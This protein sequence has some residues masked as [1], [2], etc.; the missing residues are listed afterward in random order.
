MQI[1]CQQAWLQWHVCSYWVLIRFQSKFISIFTK[2]ILKRELVKPVC[3]VYENKICCCC[4]KFTWL[5]VICFP[6]GGQQTSLNLIEIHI[7]YLIITD[8][9]VGT[10]SVSFLNTNSLVFKL[11]IL[12]FLRIEEKPEEDKKPMV[13]TPV[14]VDT[15]PVDLFNTAPPIIQDEVC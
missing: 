15:P 7:T 12:S 2:I 5:L 1:H 6:G 13:H 11:N 14:P 9:S 3:K 4:C 10:T 8:I